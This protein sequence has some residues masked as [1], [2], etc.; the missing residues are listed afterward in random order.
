MDKKVPRKRKTT[1]SHENVQQQSRKEPTELEHDQKMI[2]LYKCRSY[3][4]TLF[5]KQG[6]AFS[7]V[8]QNNVW[9][10]IVAECQDE[11]IEVGDYLKLKNTVRN[12]M[13]RATVS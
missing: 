11:G 7:Q 4:K 6:V 9:K 12:W 13:N 5:S 2:I 10:S 1:S 3:A 8:E